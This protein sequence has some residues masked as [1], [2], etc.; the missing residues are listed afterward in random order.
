MIKTDHRI[1][2]L[3]EPVHPGSLAAFRILFGLLMR[4]SFLKSDKNGF[5]TG[6]F[7]F[8]S[9]KSVLSIYSAALQN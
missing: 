5:H 7:F 1:K 4:G 2:K 9:S 6:Q 8:Y 3:F